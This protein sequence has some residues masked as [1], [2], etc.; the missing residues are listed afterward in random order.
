[1]K[2]TEEEK[3]DLLYA[4]EVLKPPDYFDAIAQANPIVR[5]HVEK[6][7]ASRDTIARILAAASE[8]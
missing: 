1:M 7:A 2:L 8:G 6:C 3:S 4:F 5:L